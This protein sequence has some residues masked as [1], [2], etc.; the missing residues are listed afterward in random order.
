[1]DAN[2]Y[3]Q[4]NGHHTTIHTPNSR[5]QP[6]NPATTPTTNAA[7][8]NDRLNTSFIDVPREDSSLCASLTRCIVDGVGTVITPRQ[9]LGILRVLKAITL[10]FLVLTIAADLMYICLLE[11][12]ANE[13]IRKQVGGSRDTIIRIY[14]L[15]FTFI[16]VG[17]ELD[18]NK[19]TKGFVGLKG[20]VPRG[21][22]LFFIATLTR[23]HPIADS[24]ANASSSN[25]NGN[26]NDDIYAA[27][28]DNAAT[29]DYAFKMQQE[30]ADLPYSAIAFQQVTSYIL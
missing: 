4:H 22:L 29:D 27:A 17:V 13:M 5:R 6:L 16:A 26:G 3:H 23:A 24:L 30:A 19:V 9:M 12:F 14:G 25:G 11:I 7:S 20:F 21:L 1:M 28:D 10:S 8:L 18:L 15:L 2:V